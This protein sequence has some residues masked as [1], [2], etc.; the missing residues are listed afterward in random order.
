MP[1]PMTRLRP[2]PGRHRMRE[3][4]LVMLVAAATTYLLSGLCRAIAIRFGIEAQIRVR[5]VHTRP[6]PYL[7]GMAMLGGVAVAFLLGSMMPF[8]GRHAVVTRDAQGI[9][10]A[11]AVIWLVGVI[12]DIIDLPAIA[13]AA[14]QVL[15][16][17]VAVLFGVRM[18]WISLPNRIIA[19]DQATS[20]IITV[21]FIFVCVNAINVMDGLDGLAA[22]VVAIGASAMF[23]YTYVLAR[24]QNFVVATTA[25]LATVTTTGVCLGFLPHN[26]HRARMFMGDAGSMLLGLLLS[27][28]SL[29]FTGQ[30]DSQSLNPEGTGMLPNWLPLALPFAVMALPL[31]DLA[32]SYIRRTWHGKWWFVADKQ[33]LHHRLIQRGHSVV[34]AVWVLYLWSAVIAYGAIAFGL[35]RLPVAL[36]LIAVGIVI[37]VLVTLSPGRRKKAPA[38]V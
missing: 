32:T 7:G 23:T 37:A 29:S 25:S 12:D 22:G 38:G 1:I 2:R 17:G 30:I 21:L 4:L 6:T 31:F 3:Y 9:L 34:N 28:S 35:V 24:E 15:A 5:D 14:G 18:Y 10:A 36:A 16:A 33:H 20:I 27:C 19:L 13:K 11:G 26:F 8:L